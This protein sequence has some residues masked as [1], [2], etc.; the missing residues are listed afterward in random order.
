MRNP[1]TVACFRRGAN[2]ATVDV[3]KIKGK[4]GVPLAS[5]IRCRSGK[6]GRILDR[7]AETRRADHRTVGAGKASRCHGIPP[8]MLGVLIQDFPRVVRLQRATG[9]LGGSTD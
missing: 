2:V 6:I 3:R 8:G 4:A 5:P 7:R 1:V 9:Q